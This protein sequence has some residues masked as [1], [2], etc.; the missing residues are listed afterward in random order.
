MDEAIP[1]VERQ[2]VL[3]GGYNLIWAYLNRRKT[4][5][6]YE[7]FLDTNALSRAEWIQELP[8]ELRGKVVINPFYAFLEQWISN[9]QFQSNAV[10]KMKGFLQPF[11]EVGVQ[12]PRNI[13]TALMK[14]FRKNDAQ[15]RTQW[16]LLFFYIAI[17]KKVLDHKGG[18]VE[19]LRILERIVGA[20]IPR[21]SGCLIL[22]GL[23]L[24]LQSKQGLKLLGDSKPAFSFLESF[25]AFQPKEKGEPN[26]VSR[27]YLRNRA[28]DLGLWYLL[29]TLH[30]HSFNQAGDQ[31]VVTKDKALTKVIL[32][33]IPPV[34]LASRQVSFAPT[35]TEL[36][37]SDAASWRSIID[38]LV[39]APTA[40]AN[41]KERYV[42]MHNLYQFAYELCSDGAE[43]VAIDAI[44][45]EWFAKGHG[46]PLERNRD[47]LKQLNWK[48]QTKTILLVAFSSTAFALC[49][50]YMLR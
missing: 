40:P 32:R 1:Y 50:A 19:Q 3:S 36:S 16:S 20:D 9:P 41:A 10:A 8:T 26:Y 2:I 27:D 18:Q 15:Y 37:E 22:I 48:W 47:L 43:R 46:K 30:Q 11:R 17:A 14:H 29:P 38:R 44:W 42:R 49:I 4:H 12:F 24:H 39:R 7:L 31:I 28:G 45:E 5:G 23:A 13:E 33:L 25:F 34:V 35:M 6:P 21:F